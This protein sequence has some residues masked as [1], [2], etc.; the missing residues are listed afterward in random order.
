MLVRLRLLFFLAKLDVVAVE[1]AVANRI[2]ERLET[3]SGRSAARFLWKANAVRLAHDRMN[4]PLT[5]RFEKVIEA[6]AEHQGDP[7]QGRQR[8]KELSTFNFRQ[9]RRR[10]TSVL[11]KLH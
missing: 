1:L 10:Q 11:A 2:V 3:V 7:Q 4:G 8:R 5:V 9:H 6:N